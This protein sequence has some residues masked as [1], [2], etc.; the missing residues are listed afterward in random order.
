MSVYMSIASANKEVEPPLKLQHC[1]N[2]GDL[3]FMVSMSPIAG[4]QTFK[5]E[6]VELNAQRCTRVHYLMLVPVNTM[7]AALL[8]T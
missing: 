4:L 8:V 6:Q 7:K 5:M 2:W 3:D 1:S